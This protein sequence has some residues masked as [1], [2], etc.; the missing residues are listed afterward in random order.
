MA[1]L[2]AG[3]D[4]DAY[5]GKCKLILAHVIIAMKG[6]R[7]AR[8]ECKTCKAQHAYRKSIP[9][10]KATKKIGSRSRSSA[11][12]PSYSQLIKGRDLNEAVEYAISKTLNENDIVAHQTFGIGVVT[13]CLTDKKV[14]VLFETESKVLVHDR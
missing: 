14:T 2:S 10:S 5:C 1:T 8:V 3:Q 4:I 9:G 7:A 11:A 12:A 6:T 13:R